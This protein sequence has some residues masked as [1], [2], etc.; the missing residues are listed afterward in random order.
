MSKPKA[1]DDTYEYEGTA[2]D[3]A[4][5]LKRQPPNERFRVSRMSLPNQ[6]HIDGVD[7][8]VLSVEERIKAMDDLAE[9]NRNLSVLPAE[10]FDREKLYEGG[11]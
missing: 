4:R 3:I 2:D 10:A 9:R 8:P 7:Y 11:Q 6:R 1:L 5:Y